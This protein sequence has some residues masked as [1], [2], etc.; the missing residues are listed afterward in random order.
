[1]S[2]G[3]FARNLQNMHESEK[4]SSNAALSHIR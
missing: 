2:E 3:R 1:M 4:V